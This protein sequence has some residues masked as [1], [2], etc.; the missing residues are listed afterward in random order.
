MAS[1]KISELT[2]AGALTG[3]ELVEIVQGGTNKQ[4]TTQDIANLGG[5]AWGTITG[6]L[7]SQTDLQAALDA[8]LEVTNRVLVVAFSDKV[9]AIL[10]GT[11]KENFPAPYTTTILEIWVALS[12]PQA[13]GSIFTVDVNINGTTMLSTKITVDNGENTSLTAATACVISNAAWTK[14]D[15][16]SIDVDQIGD[17]TA[18][19]G[20][21]VFRG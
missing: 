14:G 16:I 8:R 1:K 21:I 2:A 19:S 6:T 4:S 5:G 11:D 18:I 3:A 10:A 15:K 13:S 7:S 17:G 9:T 20:K 12:T